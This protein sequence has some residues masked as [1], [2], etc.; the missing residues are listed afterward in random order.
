LFQQVINNQSR[1]FSIALVEEAAAA[2]VALD[3]Q[4]KNL[5]NLMSY[6]K[7]NLQA[8]QQIAVGQQAQAPLRRTER[9]APSLADKAK[10]YRNE[11]LKPAAK[12]NGED[13]GAWE[14][15]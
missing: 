13:D 1:A 2:S 7:V 3:E 15:F 10:R 5:D 12:R 9:S 8:E 11:K 4:A 14:E 6:F